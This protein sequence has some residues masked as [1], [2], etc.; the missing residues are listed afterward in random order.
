MD[1]P[2]SHQEGVFVAK[3]KQADKALLAVVKI[4]IALYHESFFLEG[5]SDG[6]VEALKRKFSKRPGL[7]V[8][9]GFGLHAGRAVEGAIGSQRKLDATYLSE[10]VELSEYL[11]SSTKKYGVNILMSGSFLKLLHPNVSQMCRKIDHIFLTDEFEEYGKYVF[12]SFFML[13]SFSLNYLFSCSIFLDPREVS[14]TEEIS[15]DFNDFNIHHM[16]LHTFDMDIDMLFR[17][18]NKEDLIINPQELDSPLRNKTTSIRSLN[19]DDNVRTSSKRSIM[20]RMSIFGSG[21]A[22]LQSF[23]R[24]DESIKSN[25]EFRK[26]EDIAERTLE[27]PEGTLVYTPSLWHFEE[28]RRIRSRFTPMFFQK[29]KAGYHAYISGDWKEA[30]MIFQFMVD[31]YQDKP[32]Q[33]FLDKMEASNNVAPTYFHISLGDI[34]LNRWSS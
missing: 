20:R 2:D 11:E 18:K 28:I 8:Q 22:E 12:F 25:Q 7:L 19:S 26:A 5:L 15:D 17:N 4:C 33:Y 23:R 16:S 24:E 27:I 31:K 32:S 10:A 34:T 9:L 1:A 29:F 3:N 21:Q 13:K 6:S 30:N 14:M